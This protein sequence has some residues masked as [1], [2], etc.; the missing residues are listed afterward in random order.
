[1]HKP[2]IIALTEFVPKLYVYELQEFVIIDYDMFINEH[3][4]RG[5]LIY[6]HKELKANKV[7]VLHATVYNEAVWCEINLFNGNIIIATG[8][9]LSQS[10]FQC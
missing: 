6:V 7:K 5:T 8:T 3:P 2:S 1:M 9:H 4:R 10:K